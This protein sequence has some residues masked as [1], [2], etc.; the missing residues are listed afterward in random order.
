M[1]SLLLALLLSGW[2][3]GAEADRHCAPRPLMVA[4]LA[5]Q[6]GEAPVAG[7]MTRQD[8]VME[9]FTSK[10]GETFTVVYSSLRTGMSCIAYHGKD[11]EFRRHEGEEGDTA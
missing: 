8:M 10:A 2:P 5:D 9:V 7:G 11:W 4:A 1:R 6:F 3:A